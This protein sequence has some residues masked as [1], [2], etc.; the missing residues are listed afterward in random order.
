ML[1]AWLNLSHREKANVFVM[2]RTR[3]MA[4]KRGQVSMRAGTKPESTTNA[5]LSIVFEVCSSAGEITIDK[6][7]YQQEAT[8]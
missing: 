4:E 6:K 7:T 8:R 1:E 2:V 5:A 3:A